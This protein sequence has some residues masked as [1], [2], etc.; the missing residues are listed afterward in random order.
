MRTTVDLDED[1][2]RTS[3]ALAR[4]RGESLG[5]VISDLVRKGLKPPKPGFSRSPDG[6]PILRRLPG[7]K[8]VT[9]EAVRELLESE[10]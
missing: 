2:L 8:P 1:V 6:F 10:Y 4:E 5:R 9:S 3:K 7:A